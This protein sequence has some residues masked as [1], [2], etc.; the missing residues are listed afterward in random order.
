MALRNGARLSATN[1]EVFP[2]GCHLLPDSIAEAPVTSPPAL[3]ARP[4]R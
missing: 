1:H 2:A 3:Q 4:S